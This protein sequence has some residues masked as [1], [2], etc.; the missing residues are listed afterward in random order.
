[1]LLEQIAEINTFPL[2]QVVEMRDHFLSIFQ[3]EDTK[4]YV[5]NKYHG[6]KY[7]AGGTNDVINIMRGGRY[8]NPYVIEKGEKRISSTERNE[9]RSDAVAKH[10]LTYLF[11]ERAIMSVQK[12]CI[13]VALVCCCAPK[14]CH[15]DIYAFSANN[16]WEFKA[17]VADFLNYAYDRLDGEYDIIPQEMFDKMVSIYK[18]LKT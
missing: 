11:N 1:M 8:G 17:R 6:T 4:R 9:M 3:D 2:I 12:E 18:L 14:M 7:N 5:H 15:G 13:D 10:L 16:P